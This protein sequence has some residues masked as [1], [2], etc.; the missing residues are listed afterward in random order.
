M[1]NQGDRLANAITNAGTEVPLVELQ[2]MIRVLGARVRMSST[3]RFEP[4]ST[5]LDG[6]SRSNVLQLAQAIR[7]GRFGRSELLLVG[8]SD[9]RG[10]ALA[11]RDLSSARAEAVKQDVTR[12]LGGIIPATVTIETLP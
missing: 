8:F 2:R 7:D 1:A 10:P 3:F 4:G 6:Q 11:N 12:A 5:R 9:G